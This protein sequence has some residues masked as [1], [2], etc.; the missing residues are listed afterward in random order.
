M[1]EFLDWLVEKLR[2][3]PDKDGRKGIEVLT[4]KSKLADSNVDDTQVANQLAFEDLLEILQ[5]NK[6]KLG[7]KLSND[8]FMD[9]VRGRFE[10]SLGRVLPLKGRLEKTDRLIDEVVYRLY[11]LTEEEVGVVEGRG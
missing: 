9:S 10:E 2:I 11:G 1:R 6:G 8:G 5:K 7:V 3:A 4:G